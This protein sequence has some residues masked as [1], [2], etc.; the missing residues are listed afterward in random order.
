M[1]VSIPAFTERSR[2]GTGSQSTQTGSWS[3]LGAVEGCPCEIPRELANPLNNKLYEAAH[4]GEL[5]PSAPGDTQDRLF[6][7]DK[8]FWHALRKNAVLNL[9]CI[10][11]KL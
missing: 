8:G 4:G 5:Y 1:S 2:T 6:F 11:P 7:E 3:T 10:I 9:D